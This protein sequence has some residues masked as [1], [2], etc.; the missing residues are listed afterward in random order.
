MLNLSFFEKAVIIGNHILTTMKREET[1]QWLRFLGALSGLC[2]VVAFLTFLFGKIVL[3][4][5]AGLI[6]VVFIIGCILIVRMAI[7]CNNI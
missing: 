5:S 1:M 3:W 7:V 2:V 6:L 4:I